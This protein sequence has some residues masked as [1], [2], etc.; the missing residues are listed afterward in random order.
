MAALG[1]KQWVVDGEVD[2]MQRG[3]E[4]LIGKLRV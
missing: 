3:E 1:V 2:G 4:D